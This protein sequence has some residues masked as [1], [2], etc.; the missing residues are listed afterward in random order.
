[1]KNL[2]LSFSVLSVFLFF[3]SCIKEPE[4][5][6]AVIMVYKLDQNGVKWPVG[7]CEVRIEITGG[8]SQP[9]L[10]E[11]ASKAKLTGHDGQVEYDFKYEGIVYVK[12][13]K[14]DGKESCGRGVL[15]LK[16]GQVCYEE[17]RLSACE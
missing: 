3:P 16:E 2:L 4:P 13:Q 10:I 17:I 12:A 14:G 9:E 6:R 15:I 5:P 8:T 11:Y 1:M 7:N